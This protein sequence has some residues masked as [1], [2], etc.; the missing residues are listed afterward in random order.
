MPSSSAATRKRKATAAS[1]SSPDSPGNLL[2]RTPSGPLPS[3][4]TTRLERLLFLFLLS[5]LALLSLHA[6]RLYA[7][8]YVKALTST[9]TYVSPFSSTYSNIKGIFKLGAKAVSSSDPDPN[10]DPSERG[11]SLTDVLLDM[12]GEDN[13]I[14]DQGLEEEGYTMGTLEDMLDAVYG[15]DR[16]EGEY[17]FKAGDR[18][19]IGGQQPAEGEDI[20]ASARKMAAKGSPDERK[21]RFGRM[22]ETIKSWSSNVQEEGSIADDINQAAEF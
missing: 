4:P 11:A 17:A 18:V 5:T 12:V 3:K 20:K 2:K 13:S 14:E 21:S 22:A 15:K 7:R 6:Y 19:H 9:D 10:A 8:P 16:V 1:S